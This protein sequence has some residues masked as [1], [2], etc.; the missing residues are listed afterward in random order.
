M[1]TAWG[2]ESSRMLGRDASQMQWCGTTIIPERWCSFCPLDCSSQSHVRA[3][4]VAFFSLSW[5]PVF[6][7]VVLPLKICSLP[8][9]SHS[10]PC[11][12]SN[13]VQKVLLKHRCN[14]VVHCYCSF[15][16]VNFQIAL[17]ITVSLPVWHSPV[18]PGFKF[19][20]CWISIKDLKLDFLYVMRMCFND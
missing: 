1:V 7:C 5:K 17:Y 2:L 11:C 13:S 18:T 19:L 4:Q 20:L 16:M 12:I 15:I 9:S 8:L 14:M 6:S 3:A 10:Q